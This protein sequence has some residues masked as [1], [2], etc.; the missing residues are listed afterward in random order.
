MQYQDILYD[1]YEIRGYR[2]EAIHSKIISYLGIR[3]SIKDPSYTVV[4]SW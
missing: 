2:Y 1:Q 3:V 4:S